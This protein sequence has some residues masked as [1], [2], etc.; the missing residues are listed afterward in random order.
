MTLQHD[1]NGVI[2][3]IGVYERDLEHVEPWIPLR[4]LLT[5]AAG[6]GLHRRPVLFKITPFG[7]VLNRLRFA[8]APTYTNSPGHRIYGRDWRGLEP[9][10]HLHLFTSGALR[11]LCQ[12]AGFDGVIVNTTIRA[13]RY[14]QV[15]SPWL[16]SPRSSRK[17][18]IHIG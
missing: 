6:K 10:R 9:P 13:F 1:S 14:T 11:N 3:V 5:S 2:A 7:R 16:P 8:I 12:R 18:L 15:T 4:T 17:S